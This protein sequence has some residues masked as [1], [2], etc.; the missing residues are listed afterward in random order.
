MIDDAVLMAVASAL[1]RGGGDVDAARIALRRVD[2]LLRSAARRRLREAHADALLATRVKH[3]P[4]GARHG[5]RLTYLLVA[6]ALPP[7]RERD[8]V[9]AVA[10]AYDAARAAR[11]AGPTP[12]R[13]GFW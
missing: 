11:S 1:E 3:G 5:L 10:M 9:A 4:E 7:A 8:D 2:P 13:S 6:R 12:G